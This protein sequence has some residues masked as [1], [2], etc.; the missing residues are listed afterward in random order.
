[1]DQY[2]LQTAPFTGR[3]DCNILRSERPYMTFWSYYTLVMSLGGR[4][5][6]DSGLCAKV[7]VPE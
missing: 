5:G 1:M 4:S 3:S 6:S 7:P 2:L